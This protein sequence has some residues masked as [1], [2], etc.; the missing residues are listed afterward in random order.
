MFHTY[1]WWQWVSSSS[2]I[3]IIPMINQLSLYC[4]LCPCILKLPTQFNRPYH[5]YTIIV[6]I[7]IIQW[8]TYNQIITL[9]VIIQWIYHQR[10]RYTTIN[11][12]VICT[13]AL[14]SLDL[15]SWSLIHDP[16]SWS[17]ILILNP[18]P[19]L[20]KLYTSKY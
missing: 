12:L 8:Y 19:W 13:S 20:I 2:T 9:V 5:N 17:S 14:A 11:H 15:W 7:I 6:L 16:R 4:L 10:W 18:D 3:I 1:A